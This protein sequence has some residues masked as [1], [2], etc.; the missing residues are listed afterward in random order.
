MG[1]KS[2]FISPIIYILQAF[3]GF[4]E[5]ELKQLKNKMKPI[6]IHM[7]TLAETSLYQ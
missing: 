3:I 4:V 1:L 6:P 2:Q 7:E 5:K